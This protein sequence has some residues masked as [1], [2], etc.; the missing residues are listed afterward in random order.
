MCVRE[1]WFERCVPHLPLLGTPRFDSSA[2]VCSQ[3]MVPSHDGVRVLLTLVHH[4]NLKRDKRHAFF[5]SYSLLQLPVLNSLAH[6]SHFHA[7][8]GSQSLFFIAFT[9]HAHTLSHSAFVFL[10]ST[11]TLSVFVLPC[12]HKPRAHCL[13]LLLFFFALTLCLTLPLRFCQ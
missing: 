9:S 2:Y 4:K 11:L 7:H 6:Q 1:Y 10:P 12:V 13:T 5:L 8:L 3:V